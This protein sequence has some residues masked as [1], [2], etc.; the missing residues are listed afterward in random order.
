MK[1]ARAMWRSQ[2]I[3]RKEGT[4]YFVARIGEYGAV[5]LI[6]NSHPKI[7]VMEVGHRKNI[8]D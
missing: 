5:L 6:E 1:L 8:Y 2:V 4:P 7:S 3:K